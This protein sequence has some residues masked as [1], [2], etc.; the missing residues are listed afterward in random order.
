MEVECY[1]SSKVVDSSECH[2]V[3]I[4][5][6]ESATVRKGVAVYHTSETEST[7]DREQTNRVISIVQKLFR[8][9]IEEYNGLKTSDFKVKSVGKDITFQDRD[10]EEFICTVSVDGKVKK[11][12]NV[13]ILKDE[14]E[15]TDSI[16][17]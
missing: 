5:S 15:D 11:Y 17:W 16:I 10:D 3:R 8:S 12:D 2:L 4:E 6:D 13:F 9:K 1:R 7:L 14:I